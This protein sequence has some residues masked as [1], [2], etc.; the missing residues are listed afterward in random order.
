MVY[1]VIVGLVRTYAPWV[2]LPFT[3]TVG[4]VGYKLEGWIRKPVEAG[5]STSIEEKR[6]ERQLKELK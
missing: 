3:I 2:M 6:H 5:P 4:Y 1:Q